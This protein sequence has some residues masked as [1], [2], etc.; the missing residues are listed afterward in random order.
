MDM[1]AGEHQKGGNIMKK[2]RRIIF[3]CFVTGLVALIIYCAVNPVTGKKELMFFSVADELALGK[4][5]DQQVIQSYGLYNDPELNA[6]VTRI[7][8]KIAQNTHRPDLPYSFKVL[9]TP[10]INAFA[11][12]GGYVYVTR[13]ILGYFNNEAE[14]AGVVGHEL[15]HVNARHTMKQY[16]NLTLAQL[17]LGLASALSED[18]RKIAGIAEFGV[19]MLFLRFSR[20]NER[21]ADDLGVEYSE[22]TGYDS[23]KMA[24][25]FT[26]LERLN[27]GSD[28]SGLPG[29]FSTHPN[30]VDRIA[31]VNQKSAEWKRLLPQSKNEVNTNGY[32]A[33][34]DGIIFGEDPRQG[35]VEGNAFYHPQLKFTFIIPPGWQVNNT[36]SQ[37]QLTPESQDASIIM[38]LN[39]TGSPNQAAQNY[40][41]TSH[42]TIQSST[43]LRVNNLQAWQVLSQINTDSDSLKVMSYFIRKDN[44]IY[45]FH[46]LTTYDKYNTYEPLFSSTL[47]GFKQ[48]TDPKKLNVKPKKLVVNTV[49]QD[50]SARQILTTFGVKADE[51]ETVAIVNGINLNDR[52]KAGSKIKI[53]R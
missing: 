4:E 30:P 19:G 36:P 43:P 41:N 20:D 44:M 53:I 46:G 21:Q 18:F 10:V 15:G 31:A 28:M 40:I 48:L 14:L 8:M 32:L 29:W 3:G 45:A 27:P 24:E 11:V 50:G 37:L 47:R 2:Y 13:G 6:Y 34:V 7:G 38:T 17:G 12:P 26:T 39:Q 16:T 25:F 1:I 9:D 52:L 51:L 35:Y 42:A 23:Q 49:K 22:K 33:Q 5:T